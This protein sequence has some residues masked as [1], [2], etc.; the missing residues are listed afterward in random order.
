MIVITAVVI[1]L[2]IVSTW[3]VEKSTSQR[4]VQSVQDL[5]TLKDDWEVMTSSRQI[6]IFF[7]FLVLFT[8]GLFMQDPILESFGAEVFD[9]PVSKTT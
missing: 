7:G 5:V 3:G 1:I 9:M 4:I 6:V 2:A 8:I